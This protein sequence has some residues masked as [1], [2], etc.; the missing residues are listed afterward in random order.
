MFFFKKKKKRDPITEIFPYVGKKTCLENPNPLSKASEKCC[1]C[2][3]QKKLNI[4]SAVLL[5]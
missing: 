4:K 1:T 3:H 5:N 2:L